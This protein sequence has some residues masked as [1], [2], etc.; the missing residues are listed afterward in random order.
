MTLHCCLEGASL[1]GFAC[2]HWLEAYGDLAE[3]IVSDSVCLVLLKVYAY[4]VLRS[5]G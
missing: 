1:W 5:K 4:V 3:Q 2:G